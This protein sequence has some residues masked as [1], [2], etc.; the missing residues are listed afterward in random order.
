MLSVCMCANPGGNLHMFWFKSADK[1][2]QHRTATTTTKFDIYQ[3]Y[4]TWLSIVFYGNN[5]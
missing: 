3:F 2:A 4:A 1:S 5:F